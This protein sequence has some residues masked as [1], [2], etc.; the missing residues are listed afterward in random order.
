M[1]YSKPLRLLLHRTVRYKVDT[2][3]E[4]QLHFSKI[5][6]TWFGFIRQTE[7]AIESLEHLYILFCSPLPSNCGRLQ[8]H[9]GGEAG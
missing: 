1:I 4:E 9:S 8:I 3:E 2:L 5:L 7:A 6:F